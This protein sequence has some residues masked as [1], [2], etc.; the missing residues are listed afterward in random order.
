MHTQSF[1][2]ISGQV[3]WHRAVIDRAGAANTA[4]RVFARG[5]FF[6]TPSVF[7]RRRTNLARAQGLEAQCVLPIEF[8][9]HHLT[10]TGHAKAATRRG[11]LTLKM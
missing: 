2:Q 7:V 1:A 5:S 4:W 10:F 8:S 6:A 3:V 9:T 11:P